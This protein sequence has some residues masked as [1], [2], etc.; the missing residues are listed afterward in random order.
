MIIPNSGTIYFS[1]ETAG[2]STI[3]SL[4][5]Q[6]VSLA[7]DGQAGLV[8]SSLNTSTSA[9]NRFRV[10]GANG[11]LL[12]VTDEVTGIVFIVNDPAGLPIISADTGLND[13]ITI[14][15]F[16]SNALVVRND[17]VGVGTSNPST[18]AALEIV[19]TTRGFRPPVMTVTQRNAIA[20]PAA[21]LVVY[22]SDAFDLSLYNG[23]AWGDVLTTHATSFTA[24]TLRTACSQTQ[25]TGSL[26]FATGPS[27][28]GPVNITSQDASTADRVMTRSLVDSRTVISKLDSNFTVNNNAT[29]NAT[30]MVLSL[31]PGWWE[32][33]GEFRIDSAVSG[34]GAKLYLA[35]TGGL[36]EAYLH[37]I[38]IASV[39]G[40]STAPLLGHPNPTYGSGTQPFL[41]SQSIATTAAGSFKVGPSLIYLTANATITVGMSQSTANPSD[42]TML[43][44]PLSRIWAT[45]LQH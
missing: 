8:V 5:G 2:A 17:R 44:F 24:D 13:V 35:F 36:P 15:T 28:V 6:A 16:G 41:L 39:S 29:Y 7:H 26:V 19:S 27:L 40:G 38:W 18:S 4:T 25:G 42:T 31:T 22:S 33:N 9:T 37:R 32:I 3:P 21:G 14:G 12:A 30:S 23:T 10:N 20:S 11:A 1:T 34:A 43:A 45:R